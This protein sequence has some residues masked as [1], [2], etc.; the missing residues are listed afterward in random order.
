[1]KA[2]VI[3]S[4]IAH[5]LSPAIFGYISRQEKADLDYSAQEVPLTGL[6][7]FI[8]ALKSQKDFVGIN[9]TLPLKESVI[10]EIDIVSPDAASIGA[11]N[12]IQNIQGNLLGFNTDVVGIEKTFEQKRFSPTDKAC[13]IMGAGGSAKAV[14]YVL[15]KLKAKT[16]YLLNARSPRGIE[17]VQKYEM[18]FQ[19]TQFISISSLDALKNVKFSLVVN[20]TPVGMSGPLAQDDLARD[21]FEPLSQLTFTDQ[22]LAFDLIYTPE[23]TIFLTVAERLGLS[24][25]GGLDMLIDQAIATWEIW[26]AP[27]K[28]KNKLRLGLRQFLRGFLNLRAY[29]MPLFLTGFMGVGKSTVGKALSQ[30]TGRKYLDT[31]QIIE[32]QEGQTVQALFESKGEPAFRE[33]E[34]KAL[35]K[36]AL[37]R[38][39]IISLGG[40]TLMAPENLN[41]TLAA[42]TLIYLSAQ[43]QTLEKRISEQGTPRPLLAGLDST[44][45]LEKIK[46]LM[47]QR[48]G[49]YDRANYSIS[50]EN[51][52]ALEVAE[53]ILIKLGG[54]HA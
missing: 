6:N 10:R 9:V 24:T 5:S 4:P 23:K 32:D 40:G 48:S 2:A 54:A 19:G 51:K 33:L 36:A 7:E 53:E 38:N 1:M 35:H 39:A 46:T 30:I 14:A 28:D 42:G 29:P 22:A 31:D 49:T 50:T 26:I 12:V 41:S 47:T 21:F 27:L 15:G 8:A 3:G 52:T 13:L 17:V 34:N 18:L 37:E 44:G 43:E 11:V 16:V 45:R 25:M 20:A